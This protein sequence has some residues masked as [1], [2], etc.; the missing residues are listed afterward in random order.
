M[1]TNVMGVQ[2]RDCEDEFPEG[3]GTAYAYEKHFNQRY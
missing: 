1:L 2:F 3:V